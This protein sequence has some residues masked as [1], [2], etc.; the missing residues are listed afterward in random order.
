MKRL[1]LSSLFCLAAIGATTTMSGAFAPWMNGPATSDSDRPYDVDVEKLSNPKTSQAAI[2]ALIK[3]GRS[4][5]PVL[6]RTARTHDTIAV[7]GWAIHG[8]SRIDSGEARAALEELA[9]DADED[10]LVRTW[11]WAALVQEAQ[12]LDELSA[13]A[14]QAS[15]FTALERPISKR[16]RA[17]ASDGQSVESLLGLMTRFPKLSASLGPL[18]L[19]SD[20]RELVDVMLQGKTVQIRQQAASYLATK[21][22]GADKASAMSALVDALRLD[23]GDDTVPWVG[24]A[25]YI[26]SMQWNRARARDVVGELIAWY[27]YCDVHGLHSERQKITNNLRSV[28]LLGQAGLGRNLSHD[29]VRMLQIYGSQAGMDKVASILNRVGVSHLPKYRALVA[30]GNP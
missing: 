13:L 8:L 19:Q 5:I 2:Q 7:R 11:A 17:L 26:P 3:E 1:M 12:D 29:S 24:G 18:L 21:G 16:A 27:V 4:S 22:R 30:Q 28:G 15:G 10:R 9:T 14:T 20:S 23:R 25:L 6:V